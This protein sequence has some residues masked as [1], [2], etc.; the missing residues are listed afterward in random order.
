M[1]VGI[2]LR[3]VG[4]AD[5]EEEEAAPYQCS[6]QVMRKHRCGCAILT[7]R[8]GTIVHQTI[9]EKPIKHIF[10]DGQSLLRTAFTGI[11]CNHFPI[12]PFC[13]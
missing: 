7:E 2:S 11:I 1:P 10:S 12:H 3:M 8:W 4:G 6:L 13:L 9:R 5:V